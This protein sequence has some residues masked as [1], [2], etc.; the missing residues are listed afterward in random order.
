MKFVYLLFFLGLVAYSYAGKAWKKEIKK[1]KI[2]I[3]QLEDKIDNMN[4]H[5]GHCL[6]K[7]KTSK[8]ST[9]VLEYNR[10]QN[11]SA[12]ESTLVL[13]LDVFCLNEQFVVILWLVDAKIRASKKYSPVPIASISIYV[14][15]IINFYLR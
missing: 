1:L 3:D 5:D 9:S 11:T 12:T 10:L 13:S 2:R 15:Q 6:S 7:Q 8:L 14:L 4:C